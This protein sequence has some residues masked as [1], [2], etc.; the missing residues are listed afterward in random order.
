LIPRA[1]VDSGGG[2]M[3]CNGDRCTALVG[4]VGVS[5]ACAIYAIRPDVCRACTPGDDACI[6]ARQR[7]NL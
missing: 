6:M 5:T 7:F 2:R 1:Y 3:R 4:E